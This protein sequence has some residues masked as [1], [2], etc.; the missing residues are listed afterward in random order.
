VSREANAVTKKPGKRYQ[1]AGFA[2]GNSLM[3]QYAV[4]RCSGAIRIDD[5]CVRVNRTHP[6]K[7]EA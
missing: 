3:K 7:H 5:F 6:I 4:P 1:G 2:K